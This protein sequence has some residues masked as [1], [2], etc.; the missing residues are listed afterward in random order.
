MLFIQR[1]LRK[2]D[3]PIL[4]KQVIVIVTM[5]VGLLSWLFISQGDMIKQNTT[6][7]SVIKSTDLPH[8]KTEM[9][10][11]RMDDNTFKLMIELF[12]KQQTETKEDIK[13]IKNDLEEVKILLKSQQR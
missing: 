5:I 12:S 3:K 8:L 6:E 1:E 4:I 9:N 2:M 7:I 13:D 11:L 10:S